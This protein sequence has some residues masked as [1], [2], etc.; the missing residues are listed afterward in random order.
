[1]TKSVSESVSLPDEPGV[2]LGA[3]EGIHI[4]RAW[5]VSRRG[6]SNKGGEMEGA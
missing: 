6:A 1:M 2:G 4:F 3:P 5:W